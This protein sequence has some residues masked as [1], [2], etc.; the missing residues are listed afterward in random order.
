MQYISPNNHQL[1]LRRLLLSDSG[2]L[3]CYWCQLSDVTRS[4]FAPH[5][6][7]I[8]SLQHLYADGQ[9]KYRGYIAIDKHSQNIVAYAVVKM[10]YF[11]HDAARLQGYGLSLNQ[12]TDASFAPSVSDAWQGQGIGKQLLQYIKID[13]VNTEI[14]RL[15]LWGGVQASN[16]Q[17]VQYY[18]RQGFVT[19]GR[20]EYHGQNEDMVLRLDT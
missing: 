16:E 13:L 19:V 1:L 2:K 15:I 7:D 10:G 8:H 4:R 18:K 6:F 17:A 12:A 14:T 3:A 20:F 5:L 11:E 9:E